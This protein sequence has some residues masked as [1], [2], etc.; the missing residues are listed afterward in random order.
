LNI[1]KFSRRF[2]S[3]AYSSIGCKFL[4]KKVVL[5]ES[6]DWG[7]IRT[8]AHVN[9]HFSSFGF[10]FSRSPYHQFD[11]LESIVDF[12][13]LVKTLEEIELEIGKR[14][15]IT[16]NY[17]MG[18]PDFKSI[19]E[20]SF[21][22]YYFE[23]FPTTYENYWGVNPSREILNLVNSS[24]YFL[25]QFHGREH[26][27]V[28]FWLE[29][30][31]N[32]DLVLLKAFELG[33]SGIDKIVYPRLERNVQAAFDVRNVNELAFSRNSLVEGLKL[34]KSIFGFT[35]E[36]FIANNYI[37][38]AELNPTLVKYGVKYIQGNKLHH[39]PRAE[40]QSKRSFSI[41]RSGT[42][43]SDGL[44]NLVRNSAF[45]PSFYNNKEE[46][47]QKCLK[48]IS[49][50]FLLKQPAVI[51]THRINFVGGLSERNR[52]ENL[53]LFKRLLLA[54]SQRW[55]DVVFW[56]STQLGDHFAKLK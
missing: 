40:N 49:I 54:I 11:T 10:D 28:P 51:S 37:W 43:T 12:E 22:E 32:N 31:R 48:E 38:P 35:S 21:Q 5:F 7:S 30:L 17:V 16:L 20:S 15:R 34:F 29:Q 55:P 23:S 36:S 52:T 4:D 27:Q 45:E 44:L 42:Y 41:R 53:S 56:D 26:I 33:F 9:N 18:N 13:A 24:S 3:L 46:E 39:N 47:L 1:L 2:L 14:P 6:D 19:K 25:P 8:P 50:A